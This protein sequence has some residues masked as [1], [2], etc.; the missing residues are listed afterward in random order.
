MEVCSL[1]MS[2]LVSTRYVAPFGGVTSRSNLT[3][4]ALLT[5]TP[6]SD[7]SSTFAVVAYPDFS[8][9]RLSTI[10]PNNV[11]QNITAI[12]PTTPI[13]IIS[14]IHALAAI[15]A[16]KPTNNPIAAP[17]KPIHM[18]Q[19]IFIKLFL[20]NCFTK[21]QYFFYNQKQK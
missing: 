3:C 10:G 4:G 13:I 11:F 18:P 20:L 2:C 16:A 17:P 6:V 9:L 12:M 1:E 14:G 7:T 5:V 8:S 19:F 15:T 21:L